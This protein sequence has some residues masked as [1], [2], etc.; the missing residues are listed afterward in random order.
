[1]SLDR[2]DVHA[3]YL[4]GT[5]ARWFDRTAFR[6]LGSLPI[7][8][9]TPRGAIEFMDRHQ[10]AAQI[11]SLPLA[12]GGRQDEPRFAGISRQV[13]EEYA[14]LISEYPGRFGAFAAVPVDSPDS[15]LAE[16]E[17][18]LDVLKL[19][20][21]LLTSNGNGHYFGQPFYEPIF[22][23]LA[24]RRVPI[25]V[26]PEDC[27]HIADLGFGRASAVIEFPLDT[28]RTITNAIY[29][30]VFRRYPDLRMI[31]AHCGGALPALGWRIS[32]LSVL[33]GPTDADIDAEHVTE[34]LHGLYYE[35]ALAGGPHSVLPTLQVTGP[36]HIL[37]GTDWPAAPESVVVRNLKNLA[38]SDIK[39]VDRT[40]AEDL[41]PRFAI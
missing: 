5:V 24:R 31:L 30:G 41:F 19:D 13:N 21:V 35:V 40:N 34:V 1:M 22:A 29:H 37:F 3:H 12:F 33:R 8:T 7:P 23:E 6:P 36:D 18:A 38:I 25:F 32:E 26:H 10:I 9:W 11:L 16:I 15:A 14:T 2:I 27:P 4:G 28:A 17:Y 20:G 39:G